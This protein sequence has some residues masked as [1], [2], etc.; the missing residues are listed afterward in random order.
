MKVAF[1]FDEDIFGADLRKRPL[2]GISTSIIMLAEA[3]VR[4]GIK[5]TVY[6][7]FANTRSYEGVSYSPFSK[8]TQ[9]EADF[10]I[11]NNTAKPL[12]CVNKGKYVVWQHNRTSLSRI[13]RRGELLALLLRRPVLITLSNDALHN[14]P[15]FIPY[16]KM[17]VI[18]HAIEPMFMTPSGLGSS[19]R[20]PVAFFASRASRNLKWVVEAWVKFVFPKL[21]QAQFMICTPPGSD[22]PFEDSFLN[23]YNIFNKGSLKKSDLAN[24]I[25]SSRAL[26]YP[27][28]INETGCQV[29]LQ[30][31]GLGIPIISCGHGSLKD[32]VFNNETGFIEHDMQKYADRLIS[33]L[34][35]N[36]LWNRLHMATLQHPMRKTYDERAKDWIYT[37]DLTHKITLNPKDSL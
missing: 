9:I 34:T 37:L 29:A 14:T 28:H 11:A 5:V 33:V 15:K 22:V 6:N 24:L 8:S 16:K 2:G 20:S 18:P 13:W 35:N 10:V 12:L 7:T 4:L 21:P 23:K 3:F 26:A 25:N 1:I 27:G 32:L 31:I 36:D 17:H 30:A 19:N